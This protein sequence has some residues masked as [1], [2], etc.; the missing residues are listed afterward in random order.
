MRE[1]SESDESCCRRASSIRPVV[2]N[3]LSEVAELAGIAKREQAS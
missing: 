3:N 1:S 2:L